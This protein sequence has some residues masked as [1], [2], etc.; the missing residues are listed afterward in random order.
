MERGAAA[1]H[2]DQLCTVY[3]DRRSIMV[4]KYKVGQNI[5]AL[6]KKLGITQDALAKLVNV[7]PQA[8]SKWEN[9]ITLPDTGLLPVLSKLFHVQIEDLLC[10]G[11]DNAL[12]SNLSESKKVFLPGLKHYPGIPPIVSC[13]KSSLY[14]L[15]IHVSLGWISAPYAFN[16]NINETVS[17]KGPEFWNDQGCFDELVRNCGGILENFH[18]RKDD[19]DIDKKREEVWHLIREAIGKGLPCYAWELDKQQYYMIAGYDEEGYYYIEPDSGRIAGPKPYQKLGDSD[20]GILEIHIMRPGNISDNLKT[21][22]DIFEFALNVGNPEAYK[23][24]SGYSMGVEAYRVW[25]EAI[26]NHTAEPYGVAYNTSFWSRCK[27]LAGQFLSEGKL[28]IGMLEDLFDESIHSYEN[29]AKMLHRLQRI[30]PVN[31]DPYDISEEERLEAVRLLQAAQKNEIAGLNKI[32][33]ILE[34]I[35]KIW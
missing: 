21:L 18:A 19:A 17:V 4:D 32:K 16:L 2:K 24:N 7:T 25:W 23:P 27:D 15:G 6:R 13:I 8:I 20:W 1:A 12:S 10:V 33:L 31:V 5:F 11:P 30:Y 3:Q 34:E 35:Y 28:R 22:K 9:G 26:L 29:C 14:Y